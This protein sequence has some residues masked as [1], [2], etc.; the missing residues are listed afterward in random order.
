MLTIGGLLLVSSDVK[1]I[2][3]WC[4]HGSGGA[5]SQIL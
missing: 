1:V 5:G 4:H 2:I 3:V